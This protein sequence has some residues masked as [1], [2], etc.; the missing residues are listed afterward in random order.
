[1][2]RLHGEDLAAILRRQRRMRPVDVV[3]L[4]VAVHVARADLHFHA[5]AVRSDHR[6]V[7]RLVAIGLGKCDV[8]LESSGNRA[9][10]TVHDAK[11]AIALFFATTEQHPKR[12]HV[13][14]L[15]E[16][17]ALGFHL[18]MHRRMVFDPPGVFGSHSGLRE[19]CCERSNDFF[20]VL[21]SFPARTAQLA[22][23]F[24]SGIGVEH[25]KA[26]VF[27]FLLQPVHSQPVG[28]LV[29]LR[30]GG[31]SQLQ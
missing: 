9:P 24:G 18:R 22:F 27:E 25:T 6:R 16:T 26:E 12:D 23:E 1:M 4:D 7:E 5:F 30:G 17:D 10:G 8:V 13:V 2:E 20:D 28:E 14:D 19:F 15:V 21:F 31:A 11:S 3:D 29:Q